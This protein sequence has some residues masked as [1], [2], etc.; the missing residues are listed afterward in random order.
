MACKYQSECKFHRSDNL[1]EPIIS[2]GYRA[3][4]CD[5][6]SAE[7]YNCAH[8]NNIASVSSLPYR[9][10]SLGEK[11]CPLY[12]AWEENVQLKKQIA[13]GGLEEKAKTG[14]DDKLLGQRE[15]N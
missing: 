14:K 4:V 9:N 7:D 2:L 13:D 10:L 8:R 15:L 11:N 6:P 12:L 5:Y 3:N 1:S